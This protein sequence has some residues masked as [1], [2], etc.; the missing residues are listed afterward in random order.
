MNLPNKKVLPMHL[1]RLHMKWVEKSHIAMFPFLA[2]ENWFFATRILLFFLVSSNWWEIIPFFEQKAS[3]H[4]FVEA[5]RAYRLIFPDS[6]DQLIKLVHD[7]VTKYGWIIEAFVSELVNYPLCFAFSD[8]SMISLC[9]LRHFE[10]T[11][12]QIG[13]QISSSDLLGILRKCCISVSTPSVDFTFSYC[14]SKLLIRKKNK[15]WCSKYW[16][17]AIISSLVH[18]FLSIISSLVH[19]WILIKERKILVL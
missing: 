4:E 3:T 1:L 2:K 15:I 19:I 11:Q 12:Q 10:S 7:L 5:I 14:C 17:S 8:C 6:E 16:I 9:F 18:F 13:N